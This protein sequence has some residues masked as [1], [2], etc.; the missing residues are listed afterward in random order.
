MMSTSSPWHL[1]SKTAAC[2]VIA[3]GFIVLLGWAFDVSN[4][5]GFYAGITMKANAAVCFLLTGVSLLLLHSRT[6]QEKLRPVGVGLSLAA[7]IVAAATLLQ[8][9]SGWNLGIDQLLFSEAPGERATSSPGRMGINASTSFVL[10]SGALLCLYSRRA[11]VGQLAAIVVLQLELLVLVGYAYGVDE[12]YALVPYTGIALHTAIALAVLSLGILAARENEGIMA[13]VSAQTPGGTVVRRLL[14]WVLGLPVLLGWIRVMASQRSYFDTALGTAVLVVSL[15]AIFSAIVLR[16]GRRL[17]TLELERVQSRLVLRETEERFRTLANEVPVLIWVSESDGRRIWF[18]RAWLEFTGRTLADELGDGWINQLHAG[19]RSDYLA[20]YR[21]NVEKP[22]AFST[23]FRLRRADGEYRWLLET[24]S[25]R[26]ISGGAFTG[27]A[28]CCVDIT[29]RKSIERERHELL[30]S[31]RS[32][33]VELE[34]TAQL[35]DEFLAT[36]SHELRTPLNAM[37]GWS[38]IL[39]KSNGHSETT[40]KGLEVIERNARVQ[41][42]LIEDLLDMSRILTGKLRL[43]VQDVDLADVVEAAIQTVRPGAEAK[44]LRIERVLDPISQTVHGDPQRLQQVIWNLLSNA[45]KFT[46]KGGRIQVVLKRVKSHVEIL[47][48]DTGKGIK[49]AFLPHLFERFR[50]ADS[51]TTR[52]FGGLGLGLAIVKQVTELHGGRVRAASEGEGQGTTVAVELPLSVMR[53]SADAD[54]PSPHPRA[55]PSAAKLPDQ[56]CLS[57]VKVLVVDDEE[58]ARELIRQILVDHEASVV[59]AASAKEARQVLET[60][61][62]DV[63]LS[64]IGMPHQNGYE[65]MAEIRRAGHDVPA[66]AITAFARSEDRARAL[67]AGFQMHIAKPVEPAELLASVASLAQGVR[68]RRGSH[69]GGRQ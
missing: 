13:V 19:D 18:N 3:T 65:L 43:D 15:G 63:I 67:I 29:D 45:I 60:Q 41:T 44:G 8:H 22:T 47:V 9:L 62:P 66:V 21:L 54:A 51:S 50:Q 61:R 39:Q 35:K 31:E 27:M 30:E 20:A 57:G 58:D 26:Q 64:D 38:Q 37:L 24:G 17:N 68:A 11:F 4:L 55:M 36:L 48:S 42:K 59:V 49:P 14:V 56:A 53:K 25:P 10:C 1:F 28:A 46:G 12:F 7:M 69:G 16:M 52:E 34:R 23:E 6:G 2:F 32:T 5:K 40:R 33:R